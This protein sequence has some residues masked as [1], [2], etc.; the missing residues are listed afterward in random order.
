MGNLH[1][2][3]NLYNL[4]NL[5]NIHNLHNLHNTHNLHENSPSFPLQKGVRQGDTSSPK[6]FNAVLER[7][8]RKLDWSRNG[9]KINGEYLSHLRYADDIIVFASNKHELQIMLQ[10]LNIASKAVG[11]GMN[12]GKTKTMCNRFVDP[13]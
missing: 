3:H 9:I 12:Y 5:H 4:H 1:N 7:A 6:L 11:L 10:Q 13:M 2:L 8:F